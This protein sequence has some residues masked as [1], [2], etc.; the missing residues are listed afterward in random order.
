MVIP[1]PLHKLSQ[2]VSLMGSI[3]G[4]LLFL[5]YI[6][7]IDLLLDKSTID[8]YADDSTLYVS[9]FSLLEIQTNL[10]N[11]LDSIFSWCTVNN[12][13]IN[14]IKSKCMLIGPKQLAA[15]PHS[16]FAYW[17]KTNDARRSDF[18]QMSERKLAE[19]GF[20]LTNP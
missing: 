11:D 8:L 13:L 14:P 6:N 5:I 18:Y 3:L 12:M 20:E 7:D 17:L 15:F 16:L 1:F 2:V 10:Q 9:G 4:P 19:L